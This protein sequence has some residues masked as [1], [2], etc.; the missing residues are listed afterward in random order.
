LILESR[1][2]ADAC[3]KHV[4]VIGWLNNHQKEEYCSALKLYGSSIRRRR[5]L[6]N[7]AW[8]LLTRNLGVYPFRSLIDEWEHLEASA[9][10]PE[11]I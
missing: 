7:K 9:W 8:L 4:V 3:R 6:T 10:V 5:M 1:M 2:R 11:T